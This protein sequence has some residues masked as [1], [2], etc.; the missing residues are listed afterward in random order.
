[1]SGE[2]GAK[3]N[4]LDASIAPKVRRGASKQLLA[5][6]IVRGGGRKINC[7]GRW[8]TALQD[9]RPRGEARACLRSIIRCDRFGWP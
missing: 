9:Y 6:S 2:Q 4:L 5:Y 1:V 3:S 8:P 7:S